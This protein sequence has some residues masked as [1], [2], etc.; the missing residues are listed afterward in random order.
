[1][2]VEVALRVEFQRQTGFWT[3][4]GFNSNSIVQGL[5]IELEITTC[6]PSRSP[7]EVLTSSDASCLTSA[8]KAVQEG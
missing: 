3:P 5:D 4:H 2:F 6:K 1:M 7:I 8:I